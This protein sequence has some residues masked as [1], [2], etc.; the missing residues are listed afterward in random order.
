MTGTA[1]L[2]DHA[3][4]LR[5]KLT[6]QID[7]Q[8]RDRPPQPPIRLSITTKDAGL[9]LTCLDRNIETDVSPRHREPNHT[10]PQSGHR[11]R[12]QGAQAA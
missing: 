7:G 3:E 1:D 9:L 8:I 6:G 12:T 4:R 5:T 2:A 10:V 11:H